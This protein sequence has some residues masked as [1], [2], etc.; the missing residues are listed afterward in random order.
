M[1]SIVFVVYVKNPT[2]G[3]AKIATH[4]LKVGFQSKRIELSKGKTNKSQPTW[5]RIQSGGTWF[6]F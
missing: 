6:C 3:Q 1:N 4:R 2:K 5:F